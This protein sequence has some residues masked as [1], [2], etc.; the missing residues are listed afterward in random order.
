MSKTSLSPI[1]SEYLQAIKS[2][3]ETLIVLINDI[4]DLAKVDA[5]KM[6]FVNAPFNIG[7][8]LTNMLHLFDVT[9]QE[10]NLK[11]IKIYDDRIP[12]VLIGDSVRLHQILIN[13]L[14]NAIKFTSKGSITVEVALKNTSDTKV[15]LQFTISDT[16]I[17][18]SKNKLH[19]IFND[20][21]QAE[22]NTSSFYG[23]TGLGLAIVKQLVEK[24][25]GTITV[26]SELDH[27]SS[28]TFALDFLKTNSEIAIEDASDYNQ[29]ILNDVKVLVAEDVKLNQLLIKTILAG[30]QFDFDI[31]DNGK[32]AIEKLQNNSYD[33][34]LMDLQMPIMNGFEATDH[35]RN[36]MKLDIPIIAL[37]ADVT[38]VDI[39][40]CKSV[41]MNDYIAKPFDEKLLYKKIADLVK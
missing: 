20:F 4:L 10:K 5:G 37:T 31:V 33:V 17:G 25:G 11:L 30:F 40:K 12:E 15:T 9:V 13:L 16:G 35:I 29:K 24:Q 2:S 1:Q 21:E 41:G 23:G 36:I 18:I 22:H 19:T 28:F 26:N 38:T 3:G 39:D 14:S 27:G 6:I 34:I 32:I 7:S 8:S